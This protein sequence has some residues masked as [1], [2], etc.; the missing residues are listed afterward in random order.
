MIVVKYDKL[1]AA[2]TNVHDVCRCK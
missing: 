2:A 1:L